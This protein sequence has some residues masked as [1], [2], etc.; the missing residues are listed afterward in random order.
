MT[1]IGAKIHRRCP[2]SRQNLGK[3]RKTDLADLCVSF[4]LESVCWL[5]PLRRVHTH[6][7]RQFFS[8]KY[9]SQACV[10]PVFNFVMFVL[11]D[12]ST[13]SGSYLFSYAVKCSSPAALWRHEVCAW[14][15]LECETENHTAQQ[16]TIW[17]KKDNQWLE[18]LLLLNCP[19]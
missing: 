2:T 11:G 8:K 14:K 18:A 10:A 6:K 3:W 9:G 4:L 16:K 15:K 7:L 5:N 17:G 12:G 19:F 13:C 1:R